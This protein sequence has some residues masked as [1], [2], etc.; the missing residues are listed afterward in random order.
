MSSKVTFF[1]LKHSPQK[2]KGHEVLDLYSTDSTLF[3]T[4]VASWKSSGLLTSAASSTCGSTILLGGYGIMGRQGWFR[5]TYTGLPSHQSITVGIQFWLID[6]WSYEDIL[7]VYI[8]N[9]TKTTMNSRVIKLAYTE[10]AGTAQKCGSTIVKELYPV[11]LF[12]RGPHQGDT[13]ILEV[14][15]TSVSDNEIADFGM[16]QVSILFSSNTVSSLSFYGVS[17]PTT[18]I[19]E[20]KLSCAAGTYGSSS[21]SNC[22][23]ACG[24]C[25][26]SGSDS[27]YYCDTK[28]YYDGNDCLP[29]DSSCGTCDGGKATQCLTCASGS[30]MFNN[31]SCIDNCPF[32]YA[33]GRI[34]DLVEYCDFPCTTSEYYYPN[35]TCG[36]FVEFPY[37]ALAD[38]LNWFADYPC[39]STQYITPGRV[40]LDSCVSPMTADSDD[41]ILQ[42]IPPCGSS[43]PYYLVEEMTCN[44]TCLPPYISKESHSFY[45]CYR[46]RGQP[47]FKIMGSM[48]VP[49]SLTLIGLSAVFSGF[50]WAILVMIVSRM[51]QYVRYVKIDYSQELDQLQAMWNL[52]YISLNVGITVP[53]GLYSGDAL[54]EIKDLYTEFGTYSLFNVNYWNPLLFLGG[55]MTFLGIF[56]MTEL[57]IRHLFWNASAFKVIRSIRA[58]AQNLMIV[59]IYST[60]GNIFFFSALQFWK[61]SMDTVAGTVSFVITIFV[62]LASL[63]ML[64]GNFY[65]LRKQQ[66]LRK[67][68]GTKE[69]K[70]KVQKY[71]DDSPGLAVLFKHFKV[72]SVFQQSFLVFYVIREVLY[73]IIVL[74]FP[75]Y[76]L[77]QCLGILA[78][79]LVA[80]IFIATSSAFVDYLDTLQMYAYEALMVVYTFAAAVVSVMDD[81]A[82][83]NI[84]IRTLL[85]K[86]ITILFLAFPFMVIGFTVIKVARMCYKLYQQQKKKNNLIN[87]VLINNRKTDQ[88]SVDLSSS[89]NLGHLNTMPLQITEMEGIGSINNSPNVRFAGV[90]MSHMT[91]NNDMS[92]NFGGDQDM[93]LNNNDNTEN[94]F[95]LN[96]QSRHNS[97]RLLN[98]PIETREKSRTV[99]DDIRETVQQKNRA[100]MRAKRRVRGLSNGGP[101][102]A[103]GGGVQK[104][105]NNMSLKPK[106]V[107]KDESN[108]YNFMNFPVRGLQLNDNSSKNPTA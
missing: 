21:C 97:R 10:F 35:G 9:G 108:N 60:F 68:A 104:N 57:I 84:S 59:V 56:Y 7:T 14:F 74:F 85:G 19:A 40:C 105:M 24:A 94:S 38:G 62:I 53:E 63:A 106:K 70:R 20:N 99:V 16:R 46:V 61:P 107:P 95:V 83:K 55:S 39:T 89:P 52:K 58:V 87:N 5:R 101:A 29:C 12:V 77:I 11:Y 69:G 90:D 28:Y 81:D 1:L 65:F 82:S 47:R 18:L 31:G 30:Y 36:T 88:Q 6:G 23:S 33:S 93:S 4:D 43:K 64:V 17:D 34:V 76:P 103:G 49:I 2:L 26:G 78:L 22:N 15:R 42:C 3:T 51:I 54:R 32:P 80:L 48:A 79:C 72:E 67:G 92:F 73:M 75:G 13:L 66:Q 102:G 91:E 45:E 71:I 96:R 27:C 100:Q 86:V 44:T 8:S 41:G 25:Y 98:Q 37:Q 50:P